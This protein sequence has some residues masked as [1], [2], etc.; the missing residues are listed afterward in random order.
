MEFGIEPDL[1]EDENDDEDDNDEEE[2]EII[3]IDLDSALEKGETLYLF[4]PSLK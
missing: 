3:D 1:L 2:N 4:S